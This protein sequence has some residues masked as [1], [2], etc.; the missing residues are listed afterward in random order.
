MKARSQRSKCFKYSLNGPGGFIHRWKEKLTKIRII[1]I[2]GA[3]FLIFC[4]IRLLLF[5]IFVLSAIYFI[6]LVTRRPVKESVPFF[7]LHRGRDLRRVHSFRALRYLF[8][9]PV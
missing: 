9:D 2:H 3:R 4:L 8:I 1:F 6:R 5:A 7:Q